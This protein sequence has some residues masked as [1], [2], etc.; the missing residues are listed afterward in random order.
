MDFNLNNQ[1]TIQAADAEFTDGSLKLSYSSPVLQDYGSIN[2]L[3]Q[4]SQGS[5]ADVTNGT[6]KAK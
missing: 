1:H 3:T 5:V 6:K 2:Q 4:G